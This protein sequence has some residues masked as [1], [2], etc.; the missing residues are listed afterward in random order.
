MVLNGNSYTIAGITTST[1]GDIDASYGNMDAWLFNID[2]VG[3]LNW[4]RNF[5]GSQC[6]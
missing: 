2:L 6:A 3:N 1:D 4:T 5:G